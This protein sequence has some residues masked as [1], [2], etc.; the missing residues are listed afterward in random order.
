MPDT[1]LS[2]VVDSNLA[3][4]DTK[5]VFVYSQ[6]QFQGGAIQSNDDG[7]KRVYI[8]LTAWNQLVVPITLTGL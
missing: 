7:R 3:N 6:A 4:N 8:T 5:C 1:C 2:S